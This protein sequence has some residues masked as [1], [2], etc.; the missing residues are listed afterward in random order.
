MVESSQANKAAMTELGERLDALRGPAFVGAIGMLVGVFAAGA[1]ALQALSTRT[2]LLQ[3]QPHA[4]DATLHEEAIRAA[5]RD[6]QG[7]CLS[8]L[9]CAIATLVYYAML[10][11]RARAR[12]AAHIEDVIEQ[13]DSAKEMPTEKLKRLQERASNIDLTAIGLRHVDW[14]LTLPLLTVE[15]FMMLRHPFGVDEQWWGCLLAAG[16]AFACIATGYFA[17]TASRTQS[18]DSF[19]WLTF[20]VSCALFVGMGTCLLAITVQ[21]LD[22]AAPD[23]Y[24]RK[25]T[26]GVVFSLL[27]IF[28]PIVSLYGRCKEPPSGY[29]HYAA[30]TTEATYAVLDVVS[31]TGL[32][33]FLLWNGL[34]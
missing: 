4:A 21:R 26:A 7:A 19:F 14:A 23:G 2:S 18:G 1:A 13:F 32:A 29:S 3:L 8:L 6:Y 17:G 22:D 20:A 25:R 9:V 24:Q 15:I 5:T 33:L 34:P 16:F 28:Y 10:R 31:K 30:Y 27:W 11:V 12:D